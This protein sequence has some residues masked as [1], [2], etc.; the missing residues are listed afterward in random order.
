MLGIYTIL[1]NIARKLFWDIFTALKKQGQVLP[2]YPATA[3]KP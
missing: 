3:G 1:R 2:T